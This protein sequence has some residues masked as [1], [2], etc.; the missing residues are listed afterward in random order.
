MTHGPYCAGSMTHGPYCAGSMTHG[1]GVQAC[2]LMVLV[3]MLLQILCENVV[4]AR[5]GREL[6]H[7]LV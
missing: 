2:W 7:R 5:E 6:L 1:P 4:R 3:C